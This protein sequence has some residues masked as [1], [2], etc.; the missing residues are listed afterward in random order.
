VE[1]WKTIKRRKL[2]VG[3]LVV[4]AYPAGCFSGACGA[5]RRPTPF[6]AAERQLAASAPLPHTVSVVPWDSKT[7]KHFRKDPDTYARSLADLLT[8]SKAFR[9]VRFEREPGTDTDLIASSTGRYCNSA[10]IPLFTIL[11][12]GVVPT[13]FEDEECQAMVLRSARASARTS[14]EI[15]ARYRG[16]VVM[17]WL[18][19]PL[20]A[21][22]GWSHGSAREDGRYAERFRVE[23]LRHRE[24]IEQIAAPCT[25]PPS[26]RVRELRSAS[27]RARLRRSAPRRRGSRAPSASPARPGAD[28]R[29]PA[30]AGKPKT[31]TRAGRSSR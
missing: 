30:A 14:P 13:V 3:V 23:I 9:T 17:G 19:V 24:Q 25:S 15:V 2:L 6:T 20:G 16:Q 11:S 26:S 4:A 28:C 21:M 29:A 5:Y 31:A 22:P 8:K 7:G 10:V 18:A 27:T 1:L 12:F